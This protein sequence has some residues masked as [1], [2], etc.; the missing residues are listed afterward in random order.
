MK[1]ALLV[2]LIG[3]GGCL[4][5]VDDSNIIG[6]GSGGVGIG[7]GGRGTTVVAGTGGSFG[8]GGNLGSGGSLATGGSFGSG[9]ATVPD[10]GVGTGGRA[11]GPDAGAPD[12]GLTG[13]GGT[14]VDAGTGTGGLTGTGGVRGTGGATGTGGVTAAV[15]TSNAM[16]NGNTGPDMRPGA[17][18]NSCHGYTI[19]GTIY[20]TVHEPT[21][22]NGVNGSTGT[23]V[24]VTGANGATVTL[25]PTGAGNFFS[26]AAVS[27]PFTAR[28]TSNAGTRAMVG[29]LTS[30]NCN[31]CH[32]QNG[33][34]GAPGRIIVP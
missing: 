27:M 33:A 1:K 28:V 14:R 18:C 10:A 4:A 8:S 2:F 29:T 31:S 16:W 25:T 13:T 21:N 30:G 9:G 15:C 20:P 3:T 12:V 5:I 26:N 24:V 32:T 7:S 34:N 11:V 6:G 23:R 22:C 19:I 17:A